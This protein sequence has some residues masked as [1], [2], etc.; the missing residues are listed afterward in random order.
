M[1]RR[2]LWLSLLCG[3]LV[4]GSASAVS[5][6]PNGLWDEWFSSAPT[7]GQIG[8]NEW[9]PAN[10]TVAA[11]VGYHVDDPAGDANGPGGGGQ[12]YD[13][14]MIM[15]TVDAAEPTKL[16]IGLVTGFSPG[17]ES[18]APGGAPFFGQFQAG[19][20]FIDVGNDGSYEAAVGTSTTDLRAGRF[21]FD[22]SGLDLESVYYDG[23]PNP[24]YAQYSDPYRVAN[25]SDEVVA[26]P[27]VFG[28]NGYG[29]DASA[30]GFRRY[31]YEFCIDFGGPVSNSPQD[32]LIHWTM[33]CGNDNIN[34]VILGGSTPLNPVPV[35]AAAPM[36][37][38][39][40]GA[41]AFA[42]RFRRV[43]A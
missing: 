28:Y 32:I 42:R 29:A 33:E 26:S 19:D 4:A 7:A 25:N 15:W 18:G 35:P 1:R 41:V 21:W 27:A 11:G 13:N 36:A 16:Y 12:P 6:N 9:N 5:V 43:Q 2:K 10:F 17:G 14:E 24:N 22:G 38:L 31:F 8:S 20:L 23:T 39:G 37:L 3:A 30:D 34:I 40:M